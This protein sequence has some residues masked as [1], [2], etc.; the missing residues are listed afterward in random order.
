[1]KN[2]AIIVAS[3]CFD[4][5]AVSGIN[6]FMEKN[7]SLLINKTSFTITKISTFHVSITVADI[8]F[9]TPQK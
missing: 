5:S 7:S 4:F 3:F 8:H 9:I 6:I 2:V 1:M